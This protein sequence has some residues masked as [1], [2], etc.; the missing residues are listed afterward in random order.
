MSNSSVILA[1]RGDVATT[2]QGE[3]RG[4]R[5]RGERGEGR[6]ETGEGSARSRILLLIESDMYINNNNNNNNIKSDI[7]HRLEE[8]LSTPK[9]PQS[10][11]QEVIGE[12]VQINWTH[13]DHA[14]STVHPLL[15]LYALSN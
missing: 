13:H 14:N 9:H 6:G 7:F 15:K 5:E 8:P 12:G 10:D 1:A 3:G 2:L 11:P 4:R